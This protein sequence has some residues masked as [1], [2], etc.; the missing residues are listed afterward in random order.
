MR[1]TIEGSS[2]GPDAVG[3]YTI[4]HVDSTRTVAAG[5][6]AV[7]RLSPS[8]DWFT[9]DGDRLRL[10]GT[11]VTCAPEVCADL[12]ARDAAGAVFLVDIEATADE[13]A[14]VRAVAARAP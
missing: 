11:P 6:P 8:W 5:T 9:A 1:Y 12:V 2:G 13:A 10:L 3:A 4:E 7:W 14:P